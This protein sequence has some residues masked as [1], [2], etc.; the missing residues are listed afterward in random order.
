MTPL[1][2]RQRLLLVALIPACLVA[3]ALTVYFTYDSIKSLDKELRQRGLATVRH[4]APLSEYA[5]LSGQLD[6][7][8]NQA[9]AAIRQPSVKA[10]LMVSRDGHILATSGRVSLSAD[11][12]A[13][14]WKNPCWLLKAN[15]G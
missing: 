12:C 3:I 8:Q 2:V 11:H 9:A 15:T 4:L 13:C 6:Q 10:V 7:L 14:C 1:N 5:M